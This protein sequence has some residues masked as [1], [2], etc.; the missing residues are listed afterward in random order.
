MVKFDELFIYVVK[1]A[2]FCI[3]KQCTTQCKHY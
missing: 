2:Y 1:K 3:M